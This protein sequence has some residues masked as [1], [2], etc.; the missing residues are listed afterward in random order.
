MSEEIKYPIGKH[1]N[2]L[3]NLKPCKKGETRNP[4]GRPVNRLCLTHLARQKLSESCPY[5]PGKT[6]DEYLVDRW[7]GQAAEN[8]TYFKE[9]IERLEGKVLQPIGGEHGGPVI[10]KVV[11]DNSDGIQGTSAK[12]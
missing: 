12:S 6:W 9:L 2:S 1:P 8:A 5:A 7:L 4:H 3:K 10:L 11:Y